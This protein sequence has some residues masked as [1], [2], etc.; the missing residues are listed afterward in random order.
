MPLNFTDVQVLSNTVKVT[1][2]KIELDENGNPLPIISVTKSYKRKND[3]LHFVDMN[4]IDE[5]SR[6][7]IDMVYDDKI[8]ARFAQNLVD[9]EVVALNGMSDLNSIRDFIDN[10]MFRD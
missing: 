6:S 2:Q 8:L 7:S 9:G 1:S 5:P 4:C 3:L 10:Q